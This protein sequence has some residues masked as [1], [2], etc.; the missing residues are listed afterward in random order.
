[1]IE[2]YLF[3]A[4]FL[5]QIVGLSVLY[6]QQL[7][8]LIR[9]SLSRVP[10]ERLSNL[11]PG[12]DVPV[13]HEKFLV[14]YRVANAVVGL[15]GLLLLVWFFSYMQRPAWD[16]S[17]V[18]NWLTAYC[19]LQYAPVILYAWFTFR[20]NKVHRRAPEGRRKA[21]LQ[22]RGLFDFVSPLTL[23]LVIL[24]YCSFV[25][26]VF[27]VARNPFPGFGG[28]LANIGIITAGYAFF[29]FVVYWQIYGTK[30]DPL[31]THAERLRTI[32]YTVN[33]IAW[34]CVIVPLC[35]M[36]TL[37]RQVLEL[38][39]W[40]P[41]VGSLFFLS[42]GLVSLRILSRPPREPDAQIAGPLSAR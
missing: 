7:A 35:G 23:V 37:A 5:A 11:Y 2:V 39:S 24:S 13:A 3:F 29:G 34:T 26:F 40:G 30:I 42:L 15:G 17:V 8:R 14:R 38:D 36:L 19:V 9:A 41:F 21:V 22:R 20:F 6:P 31:Q 28:P 33:G 27:Y 10:A 18:G 25:A 4:V 1:M 32:G 12:V 16:E